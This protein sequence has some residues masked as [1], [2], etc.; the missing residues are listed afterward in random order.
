M[1]K[2]TSRRESL[3]GFTVPEGE[4]PY[5]VGEAGQEAGRQLEQQAE[6]LYLAGS[7]ERELGIA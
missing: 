1:A 6:N 2:A 4:E 7:R 3:S 5:R